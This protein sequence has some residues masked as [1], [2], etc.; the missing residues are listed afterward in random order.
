MEETNL[1]KAITELTFE[2]K[3]A[4]ELKEEELKQN[5]SKSFTIADQINYRSAMKR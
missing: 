1:V 5:K 4:N 2:I 3:K